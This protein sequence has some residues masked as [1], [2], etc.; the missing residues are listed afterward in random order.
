VKLA[1]KRAAE[2]VRKFIPSAL[3]AEID[4]DELRAHSRLDNLATLYGRWWHRFLERL[5]WRGGIDSAQKLFEE[6]L[7]VCPDPKSA[8]KDWK[9]TRA[10]LF[11]DAR[12]TPYLIKVETLFH[13]ELPFS[14]QINERTVLEGFIDALMIDGAAGRCL[15]LDWKTNRIAKGEEGQLRDRY[16][17]Q[18]AAYWKSISEITKLEVE[19]GIFA[20]ATGEFIPY[21]AQELDAEW[22]RLRAM[23]ADKLSSVAASLWDA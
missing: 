22:E 18:I 7:A 14:W 8:R 21:S 19:A 4:G 23:P 20:T 5:D 15:L 3:E 12:M 2:F 16:R 9:A 17:P 11:S 10:N 1:T 13:R 6:Q